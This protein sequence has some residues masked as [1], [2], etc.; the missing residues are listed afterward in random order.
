M[1]TRHRTPNVFTLYMVDVFC[2]A[3]GCVILL[4][5]A[6]AREARR[7]RTARTEVAQQ[8]AAAQAQLTSAQGELNAL[9]AA[10]AVVELDRA[11]LDKDLLAT[12][13]E[14]DAL[15]AKITRTVERYEATRRDL[16]QARAEVGKFRDELKGSKNQATA[17]A[18][19]LREAEARAARLEREADGLRTALRSYQDQATLLESRSRALEKDLDRRTVDALDAARR[20][21]ELLE[22]RQKLEQRLQAGVEELAAAQ[23]QASNLSGQLAAARRQAE[24]RFAG[25]ALTGERVVFLVDVSGS[26]KM[27]DPSTEDPAKW[28]LVCEALGRVLRSLP[29]LK[30]Y[31][32]IVF[33]DRVQYPLGGEGRW[34]DFDPATSPPSTVERLKRVTPKGETN[35]SAALAEAF[36]YR[37]QGMDTIY[38]LSDGLPNTGEGLPA[39]S[40]GLRETEKAAYLARHVRQTL[41]STWNRELPG[42]PRVRINTVGFYFDSPEVGAFL[43]ALAREH[44]GSFVGMNRP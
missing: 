18:A 9:R 30:R 8:L 23:R 17:L 29:S 6:N 28:P 42:R 33:S 35:M 44:D 41:R 21:Q 24:E 2:C 19:R 43:W 11:R 5:L 13:G 3:L 39:G 20:L 37:A 25:V 34:L 38:L 12:R 7:Q 1:Q 15:A 16:G 26:M 36:R 40:S 22:A 27:R 32:V 31:Q 4:W 14:R 10:T